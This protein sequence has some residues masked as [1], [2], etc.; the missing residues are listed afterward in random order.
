[1]A[2]NGDVPPGDEETPLLKKPP[3]PV[4]WA[5]VWILLFLQLAEP[6]TSQV[7][8]PFTPEFVRNVG[9]THGD[10]SRVG[11]YVGLMQSI[12]FATQALT[13]LHWSRLSDVVGR[14]P[15][16][17]TGLFGLS[18]SIRSLNGALNGNVGVIKSIVAEITDP[19]NL[20]Q[21]YAYMPASWSTGST[22]G[23]MIGG[24][25][26]R[27]ADQF[28]NTFGNSQFLKQYPY[29][30]PCA[31]PATFSALAWVMTYVFLRETVP[32]PVPL[33]SLLKK[34][35]QPSLSESDD[36]E[37]PYPLRR[38]MTRRVVV[39]AVINYGALSL[40]EIS[41]RAIQ[42]LFFSTPVHR[43][44]LGLAPPAIGKV[45]ACF[46]ILNSVFQFS[47]FIAGLL[48]AIPVY[49]LFPVIN[50][51]AR[52]YGVGRV[53]YLAVALQ[54]IFACGVSS[55]YGCIF[56]YISAA[57]PNRASL[58][59]TNGLAQLLVSIMRA[60]GPATSTSLFSLS[61]AEGYL[62]GGLVYA[63]LLAISLVAIAF[64]T[65]LPRQVWLS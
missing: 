42:P 46:G 38:L 41:Y 29:F 4:P 50:A 53:V 16:I 9:I 12:F 1:M 32:S 25:L 5:Q 52:A 15:I 23:P 8:Y 30:L 34:E 36:A 65:A 64:G 22:L 27:P 61:L 58:G 43:G 63:V 20:P 21:V 45:L 47:F 3:T 40:V 57:S 54:V 14:K 24:L 55:C 39:L 44:G 2:R 51:L 26:S 31:V 19:T 7:I 49:V 35:P 60:I 56:I 10:E 11:Y 48:C 62:G 17:L 18:L 6:L 28:P 59:A 13:I 37:K 33:R